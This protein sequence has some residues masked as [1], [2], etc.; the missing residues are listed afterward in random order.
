MRRARYQRGQLRLSR[1]KDG[2]KVWEYRWRE[3]QTD[4]TRKRRSKIVGSLEDYPN[5]SLVQTALDGLRLNANQLTLQGANKDTSVE[6]LVYHYREHELPDIFFKEDPERISDEDER[7]SWSTQDTYDGYLRKWILPRWRSHRL[8]EV[9]AVAVEQWLKTLSFENGDP[10][11]R[12]SKGKD[13]KYHERALR[14]RDSVGMG[15]QEPDHEC[16]TKRKTTIGSR[17]SDN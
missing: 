13:Q 8:S 12:G 17:G 4:G 16:S 15:Y 1:R 11:A 2:S 6:A 10:L 9:K 7:K 14:S 5:E 3:A